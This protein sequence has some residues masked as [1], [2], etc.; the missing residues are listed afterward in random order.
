M[1]VAPVGCCAFG[2]VHAFGSVAPSRARP[3]IGTKHQGAV[4]ERGYAREV[5][6]WCFFDIVKISE[7]MRGRR[8]VYGGLRMR[9]PDVS[10]Q[11][12]QAIRS[13]TLRQRC[14]HLRIL[15]LRD[16]NA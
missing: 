11:V 7:G 2:G 8:R 3:A 9:R 10:N 16:S 5:L 1:G 14:W 12:W 6:F 15:N 4:P 13:T